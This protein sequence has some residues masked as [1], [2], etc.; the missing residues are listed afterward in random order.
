MELRDES[1]A[2]NVQQN[3]DTALNPEPAP[4][5]TPEIVENDSAPEAGQDQ[6]TIVAEATE[7]DTPAEPEQDTQQEAQAEAVAEPEPEAA[8]EAEQAETAQ[9]EA[10][11]EAA[12]EAGQAEPE[13]ET[14]PEAATEAEAAPEAEQ[15]ET[16]QAEAE[17]T[18]AE[19]V[20]YAELTKAQLVDALAALVEQPVDTIRDKVAQIKVAFYNLRNNEIA[21]IKEEFLAKGNEESAFAVP[22]DPEEG[23]FKEILSQLKDKR[24][25]FKAAQ[26]AARADNLERK[27][28]IIAQIQAIAEDRDG[29]NRQFQR[30]QQLQQEFR[31]IGDVPAEN[32][33][34]VWKTYQRVT[35]NFYD[36]LKI[37]KEL[38]DYD[39]KKNLEIKQQLCADAEALAQGDDVL[40]SFK[41]LQE[42]HNIWRETGPVAKDVREELWNRFKAASAEVNKK[43]Q[44]FFED[45]KARE[46]ENE[47][48]KTAICEQIEAIDT[49]ALKSYAAW[50]AATKKIIAMQEDWKKLG[51]ASRRV[52][53]ELF[54]RFRKSCDDFFSKKTEFFKSMKET[55]A[56]NLQKK[57]A[58]CEKA[59]ALKDSTDWK[60][61]TDELVALQKEWKTI[62]PVVKKHSD[63]VWKRFIAACDYFFEQKGKQSSSV[64]Q[65]EHANLKAKK[66][67]VAELNALAE[68]DS[69]QAP[70]KIR[71]LMKKWQDT[72]H[73]PYKE[74]DKVYGDYR[75]AVDKAMAKH[76]MRAAQM[77]VASY[78]ESISGASQ[79]KIFR[80][81]D[82]IVR[83][84]EQKKQELKTYEN[85]MGFFNAQST[86]GNNMLKEMERKIEKIKEELA[87]MEQKIQIVDS[88]L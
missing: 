66:E 56:A 1:V 69:D 9:A 61:T 52:N 55:L 2:G 57:T 20:N 85:N 46:R 30:V 13:A 54:A 67:I 25:E 18:Q 48:A 19:A 76:N 44:T 45:R 65:V 24:A 31:S 70:A 4:E 75:A 3:T 42:L 43:Y 26:D 33:T 87:L 50:D 63:A 73:V 40:A 80:E 27:R 23:R 77:P 64:R 37:N 35:E 21:L 12:A 39:F 28:A 29:I 34:E 41:K 22:S 78:E 60:K 68:S 81:R 58:L 38:R 49:D 16:A 15:A 72:G 53:S 32:A 71:E 17:A 59:E 74:K 36:V 79:D 88:K 82:R 11:P 5:A 8:A 10:E 7:S 84:Y 51:F 62:G 83:A 47:T 14:E 86:G 6:A